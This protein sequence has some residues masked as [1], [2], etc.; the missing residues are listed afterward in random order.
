MHVLGGWLGGKDSGPLVV[1]DSLPAALA[2]HREV[3]APVVQAAGH[4]AATVAALRRRFPERRMLL[5]SASPMP[6]PA[7][8]KVEPLA[9]PVT[10]DCRRQ[11]HAAARA[12]GL[13]PRDQRK[14]IAIVP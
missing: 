5:A 9:M 11:I 4:L 14:V 1:A 10:C 6:L 13:N 12:R 2:L 7:P 8:R 3:K